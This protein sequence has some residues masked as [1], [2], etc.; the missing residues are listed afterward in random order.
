MDADLMTEIANLSVKI[1]EQ[2]KDDYPEELLQA[3]TLAAKYMT[4]AG[5]PKEMRKDAN[6]VTTSKY[7]PLCYLFLDRECEGCILKQPEG[8]GCGHQ[9]DGVKHAIING[10]FTDVAFNLSKLI[11]E[12]LSRIPGREE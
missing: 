4:I 5:L 10:T 9:Y 2:F 11:R 1:V 6:K 7:C 12:S 3:F 8:S